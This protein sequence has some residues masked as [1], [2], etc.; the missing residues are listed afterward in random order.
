[1]TGCFA[2][3]SNDVNG[4]IGLPFF[5]PATNPHRF[6]R[7]FGSLDVVQEIARAGVIAFSVEL[8]PRHHSPPKAMDAL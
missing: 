1:V 6:L 5:D 2:T 8:I 7:P 3:G 4:E